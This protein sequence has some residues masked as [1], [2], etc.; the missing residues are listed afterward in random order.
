MALFTWFEFLP[1]NVPSLSSHRPSPPPLSLSRSL[2]LVLSLS[3][4]A[5]PSLPLPLPHSH[6]VTCGSVHL[7]VTWSR[8]GLG[9]KED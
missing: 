5:H 3:L 2:S 7:V 9:T 1:P 4:H 8:L 6:H